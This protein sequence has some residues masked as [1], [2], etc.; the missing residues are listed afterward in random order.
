MRAICELAQ[1]DD[2][3]M[4]L[5]SIS[6]AASTAGLDKCDF[7]RR[8]REFSILKN[9]DMDAVWKH[10]CDNCDPLNPRRVCTGVDVR[11]GATNDGN[12]GS[13][14]LLRQ[15]CMHRVSVR[16][17]GAINAT[18]PWVGDYAKLYNVITTQWYNLG[19]RRRGVTAHTR[20]TI[21][22]FN[23]VLHILHFQRVR[24]KQKTVAWKKA[25]LLLTRKR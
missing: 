8:I 10:P 2:Q 15:K 7:L 9:V 13:R 3:K 6:R 23:I 21:E 25:T 17:I 12:D 11:N 24:Q 20:I 16:R 1:T 19:F 5:N 18:P 14:R 4:V 22:M